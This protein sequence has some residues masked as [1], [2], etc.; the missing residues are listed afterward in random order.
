MVKKQSPIR[1]EVTYEQCGDIYRVPYY[2]ES[3]TVTLEVMTAD[4]QVLRPCTQIGGS[5]ADAVARM[6][7][8]EL[9]EAG[10]VKPS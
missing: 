2:V 6:L 1:Q 9:V 7:L 4:G 3:K 8:R 5:T 10:K